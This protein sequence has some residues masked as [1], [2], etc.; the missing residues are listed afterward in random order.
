MLVSGVHHR[1]S[2]FL[3]FSLYSI[4]GHYKKMAII[5]CLRSPSRALAHN[6]KD[7]FIWDQDGLEASPLWAWQQNLV[8][9]CFP[10]HVSQSFP[11]GTAN[12]CQGCFL[13]IRKE[14]LPIPDPTLSP[15][16]SSSAL[17]RVTPTF[18]RKLCL[19]APAL[20]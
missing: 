1:F 19:T 20:P 10:K 18:S 12:S 17:P 3:F 4:I 13:R 11:M 7:G 8:S 16:S 6:P 14:S 5:P 2:L 9:D 15:K